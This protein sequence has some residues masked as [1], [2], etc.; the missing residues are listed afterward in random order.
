MKSEPVSR[1]SIH[2]VRAIK[3][4]GN[5]QRLH[6]EGVVRTRAVRGATDLIIGNRF[7]PQV[8]S[9]LLAVLARIERIII[10]FDPMR[11]EKGGLCYQETTYSAGAGVFQIAGH[12]S[13]LEKTD[14]KTYDGRTRNRFVSG[15]I[16]IWID[17]KK[18]DAE[19][20]RDPHRPVLAEIFAGIKQSLKPEYLSFSGAIGHL[21]QVFKAQLE[22]ALIDLVDG[23]VEGDCFFV[24]E[25]D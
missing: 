9:D 12:E 23:N 15:S 11:L 5:W 25:R 20:A 4:E 2:S 21:R 18:L 14:V 16:T 19:F 17:Q 13:Y 6:N 8:G 24:Q 7:W 10:K 22:N 1:S 3:P